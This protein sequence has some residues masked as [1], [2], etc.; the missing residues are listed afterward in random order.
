MR[1]SNHGCLSST[2]TIFKFFLKNESMSRPFST[3]SVFRALASDRR[4][5][6][7]DELKRRE[8][9]PEELARTIGLSGAGLSQHLRTLRQS[10]LVVS[11]RSGTQL[12][13][14]LDRRAMRDTCNWINALAPKA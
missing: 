1:V 6:V 5:R 3:E 8:L 7:L 14:R 9:R 10:G 2:L 4:R 12:F 13:Y 11:R